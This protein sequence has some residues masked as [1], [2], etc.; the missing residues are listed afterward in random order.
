MGHL[1]FTS[2]S[3]FS[4]GMLTLA[5]NDGDVEVC[6]VLL[7]SDLSNEG[8]GTD[9]VECGDT[10]QL[11][12]V[13]DTS[14]LEDL[15]GDGYCGVDG[16]G[17]DEDVCLGA[18]LGDA[19]DKALDDTGVDLEQVVTAHTG[20]ACECQH[21]FGQLPIQSARSTYGEYPRG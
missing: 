10:E 8:L 16:V 9:D 17:N 5:T 3:S 2:A 4:E 7:A 11:L 19:L 1:R 14:S 6:G 21:E 12:G 13:K 18:V 15:G 20:L